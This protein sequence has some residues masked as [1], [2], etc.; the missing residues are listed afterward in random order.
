[1]HG[2][3]NGIGIISN[4]CD[5]IDIICLQEYWIREDDF[6]SFI[7][8]TDFNKCIYSGMQGDI[9]LAGRPYSGLAILIRDAHICSAVDIVCSLIIE[10]S[11]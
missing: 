3:N 2:F 11:A 8:L 5:K 7:H 6:S 10:Y 9:R 4:L 1:M